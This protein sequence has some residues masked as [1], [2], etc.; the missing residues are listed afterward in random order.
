MKVFRALSGLCTG[1]RICEIMCSLSKT[2]VINRYRAR[3]RVSASDEGIHSPIICRHCKK[4]PCL[5]MCPITGAMYMDSTTGAVVIDD[6][7]CIGC[8]ACVEACP[9][10]AI[11]VGPEKEILKCDLCN[12]DPICTKY[13]PPRPEHSLPNLPWAEQS[14]LQYVEPQMASRPK[15][16][17]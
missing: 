13:C 1:C 15:L 12:G 5:V 8:L 16:L 2:G 9:F 14:C 3:I 7:K 4:P 10:G 6:S 11:Q 17:I